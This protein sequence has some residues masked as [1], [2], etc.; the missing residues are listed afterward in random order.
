MS[1]KSSIEAIE[2][3]GEGESLCRLR[4]EGDDNVFVLERGGA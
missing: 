3:V 2:T 1:N 4:A